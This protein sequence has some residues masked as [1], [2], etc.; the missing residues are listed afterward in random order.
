VS[1][2][3]FFVIGEISSVVI[4]IPL[5]R[6]STETETETPSVLALPQCDDLCLM[7]LAAP[8]FTV[9]F[10]VAYTDDHLTFVAACTEPVNMQKSTCALLCI[11]P[12]ATSKANHP[13]PSLA[14][15]T[16]E[17]VFVGG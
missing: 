8:E 6:L 9:M 2:F 13:S 14:V 7:R 12:L 17:G 3:A 16:Q 10:N 15:S 5:Y 11:H 4:R 1:F